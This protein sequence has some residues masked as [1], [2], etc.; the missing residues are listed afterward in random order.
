[1]C[2]SVRSSV[3]QCV[4]VRVTVC[5]SG[6]ARPCAR[7]WVAACDSACG[8]SVRQW[9]CGSVWQCARLCVGV[10]RVAVCGSADGSVHTYGART[11][12]T[13]V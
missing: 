7:Q 3:R 5:D 1:M 6:C 4:A 2:G 8:S 9:M 11:S 10:L 12:Y 13:Y